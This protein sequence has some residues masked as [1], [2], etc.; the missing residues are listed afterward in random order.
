MSM[1]SINPA[2]GEQIETF[3]EYDATKVM[4][5]IERVHRAW[6]DWRYAS[7]DQRSARFLRMARHL[8]D[9]S[10]DLARLMSREMGKP[11]AEA[12]GEVEKCA[13]VCEYYAQ[14]ASAMLAEQPVASDASRSCVAY[15]PLGVVLAV[16][17]WNFPFWQVFRFAAPALM[18][19]NAAILKH[20]SNVPRCA[21]TIEELFTETG[22]PADVFRTL[23]VGSSGVDS[24]IEHP[25]VR[26]VTLTGSERAGRKVAAK[27]GQMLKKTVLELGGSDPF[28]VMPGAD[29]QQAAMA[30]ARSRCLNS[31]Q[32]C[33]AAKRF[34]VFDEVY[35]AFLEHF[36]DAMAR[37]VIGDPLDDATQVGPQARGDLRDE[38][39]QQVLTSIAAGARLL[40]GGQPLEGPGFFYPPTILAEVAPGMPAYDEELFGPVASVIRVADEQQALT[41]ANDTPFGLGCSVWNRDARKAEA[42]AARVEAG[43]V[44]VN[45]MVK[46]D[47]RL[48]FGGVKASGYGRELARFGIQ[49]FVNVQTVWIA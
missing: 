42:L 45:G 8:R 12:R 9:R 22:F 14:Q 25:H 15:R 29:L 44:F 16:M 43:A 3:E 23:L 41:V 48:P 33:I 49:E 2:S 17:P 38:L 47:P 30:G 35:D 21:M 11:V 31:G 18:A 27:A 6:L 37:L 19:G 24:V 4:D 39:H 1:V 10:A 46:S 13:W 20:S 26:A 32:S 34:I 40:L 28:I 5:I 7:F 36:G